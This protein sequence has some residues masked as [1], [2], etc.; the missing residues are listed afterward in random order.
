MVLGQDQLQR[1]V[2][3]WIQ[4]EVVVEIETVTRLGE[5]ERRVQ[6]PCAQP[7]QQGRQ[8]AFGER[9]MHPGMTESLHR[10][11]QQQRAGRG[12]RP[13]VQRVGAP[14]GEVPDFPLGESQPF[15][16]CLRVRQ[17]CRAELGQC[18]PAR[19]ALYE[20]R[21]E[22]GLEHR[23]VVGDRR[24]CVVEGAGGCGQGALLRDRLQYVQLTELKHID[25]IWRVAGNSCIPR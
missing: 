21:V 18:G 19:P 23:E 7:L 11:R 14:F 12:E 25:I 4:L 22:M 10:R 16:H 8:F 2:Q 20:A 9:D 24:L 13:D 15:E 1:I 17:E 3:Q 6:L 5:D